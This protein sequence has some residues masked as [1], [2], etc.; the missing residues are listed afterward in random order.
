[1]IL[2]PLL[3]QI[4]SSSINSLEP[5]L[6]GVRIH[7][8]LSW[9]KKAEQ[10]TDNDAKF[11]FLWVCFNAAY[12]GDLGQQLSERGKFTD[13]LKTVVDKD[14]ANQLPDLLFKDFSDQI[15]VLISNKYI[16]EPFWRAVRE[17]GA[18]NQWK[19]KFKQ[20]I[21]FATRVVAEQKTELVL[22]VVLTVCMF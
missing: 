19:E 18:S 17:Q 6:I 14:K 11:I 20:S 22:S 13:F 15:S 9:L 3:V 10:E 12:A 1:M 5:F 7:R 2:T 21:H 8:S 4:I 16:F